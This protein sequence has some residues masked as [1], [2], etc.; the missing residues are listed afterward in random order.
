M[1]FIEQI[2]LFSTFAIPTWI[3]LARIYYKLG[4]I[5]AELKLLNHRITKFKRVLV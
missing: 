4:L 5:E 3:A 2:L 1:G